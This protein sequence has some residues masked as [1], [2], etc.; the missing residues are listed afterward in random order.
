MKGQ[1]VYVKGH[2]GSEQQ[3]QVALESFERYG[4]DV[5]PV[6]G[7]TPDTLDESEFDYPNVVNGRLYDFEREKSP[8]Y[9]TKKSCLFNHLRFYQRVIEA[10]TPMAFLEHDTMCQ[11]TWSPQTFDELLILNLD[12][13]FKLPAVFGKMAP[14]KGWEPPYDMTPV[15]DLPSNYPLK[16]YKDNHFRGSDMIAGTAAYII[17]PKGARRLLDAAKQG[18]DQSDFFINSK[19]IRMQYLSPSP[20]RFQGVNLNTSHKL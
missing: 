7:I 6:A 9:K 20:V 12:N 1:I 2:K 4:W 17:S 19:N 16:Y 14:L 18:L 5:T 11:A 15:K 3:A 13:A 8:T 10:N